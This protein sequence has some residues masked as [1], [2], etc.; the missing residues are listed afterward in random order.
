MLWLDDV[1][2]PVVKVNSNPKYVIIRFESE[3]YLQKKLEKMSSHFL[4]PL[5]KKARNTER[6]IQNYAI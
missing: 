4:N 1:S 3:S 6:Q 5:R 2:P